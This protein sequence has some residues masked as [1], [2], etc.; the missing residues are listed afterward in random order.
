MNAGKE[1][2][3]HVSYSFDGQQMHPQVIGCV[4]GPDDDWHPH[5]HGWMNCD[6]IKRY[7]DRV[8]RKPCDPKYPSEEL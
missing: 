6:G 7:P 8:I 3:W 1:R 2:V 4:C 5:H